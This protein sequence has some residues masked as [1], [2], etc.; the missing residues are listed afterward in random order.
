[1][2]PVL[3]FEKK[4]ENKNAENKPGRIWMDPRANPYGAIWAQEAYEATEKLNPFKALIFLFS[5]N[6]RRNLE[7]MGHEIEVQA[8]VKFYMKD[9][10]DY[11]KREAYVMAHYYDE[12]S[13]HSEEVIIRE[14]IKVSRDAR[15]WVN[16]HEDQIRKYCK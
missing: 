12:F 1:M 5:K 16:K 6:F 13:G 14:M 3:T 10:D 7:V 8:A 9:E 2:L 4:F 11:R 15:K